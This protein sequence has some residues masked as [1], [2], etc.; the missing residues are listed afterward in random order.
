METLERYEGALVRLNPD[1]REAVVARLELGLS[2][3]EIALEQGRGSADAARMAV[4]RA[5][6]KLAQWMDSSGTEAAS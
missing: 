1:E 5:V 4:S 3:G 6:C 2:Y